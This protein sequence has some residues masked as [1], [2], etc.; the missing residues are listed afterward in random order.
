MRFTNFAI[1]DPIL[2]IAISIYLLIHV[3]KNL[4]EIVLIFAEAN[5]TNIS[6]LFMW[7]SH[8]GGVKNIHHLHIWK[9]NEATTCATLHV[10]TNSPTVSIKKQIKSIFNK[11]G[12]SHVTVEFESE[13][14]D[15]QEKE[16]N[17]HL[18]KHTH[19]NC[20]HH[21]H[22][23]QITENKIKQPVKLPKWE[24]EI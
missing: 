20:C 9:I 17:L 18:N 5:D 15:C 1:I 4:R 8:V 21:H 7:L 16:C 3:V 13:D 22:S 2:S 10:V 19:N 6:E 12:I 11:Y 24:M 14:E 23:K